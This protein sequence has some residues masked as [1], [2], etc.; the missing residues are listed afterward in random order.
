MSFMADLQA[1]DGPEEFE[2]N[3]S[4]DDEETGQQGMNLASTAATRIVAMASGHSDSAPS[5][6][7]GTPSASASDTVL[8]RR[9]RHGSSSE[10]QSRRNKA[11]ALG[12]CAELGVPTTERAEIVEYSQVRRFFGVVPQIADIRVVAD[13][14]RAAPCGPLQIFV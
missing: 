11:F 10:G 3:G 14:A 7:S 2:N 6:P 13:N 12:I 4:Q 1:S 9:Q 5:S 8:G